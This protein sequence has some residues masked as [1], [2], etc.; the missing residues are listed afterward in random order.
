MR[1]KS[2]L[3]VFLILL[4]CCQKAHSEMGLPGFP[5][6]VPGA[7]LIVPFFEVGIDVSAH[8][9]DTLLVITNVSDSN[10][11]VH[12]HVWTIDGE[13]TKL[14]GNFELSANT[15]AS[16][17]VRAWIHSSTED[18]KN[19]LQ[20]TD[21][22]WR[23]FITFDL[24]S[25]ETNDPP[26]ATN[27]PFG[28][29]N[30]LTGYIYYTRLTQGSSNGMN[31]ISLEY[32]DT[33]LDFRINDFYDNNDGREEINADARKCS[34]NMIHGISCETDSTMDK[35]YA[36][37]F[38][39][40][41]LNVKTRFILFSWNPGFK[42]GPSVYCQANGCDTRYTFKIYDSN[43]TILSKYS[44][45]FDHTVN[46][47]ELTGQ[48]GAWIELD[49]LVEKGAFQTYAFSINSAT[50]DEETLGFKASWDAIFE[51]NMVP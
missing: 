29:K 45:K 40:P 32:L 21:S 41:S 23:G 11:T 3:L 4:A 14:Y 7:S 49:N 12:Y 28:S 46:V 15:S 34:R 35:I 33:T 9:E 10:C 51:A 18:V 22:Y 50:P 24:V 13:A 6:K 17:S 31:M 16:F 2:F 26:T 30:S 19:K 42:G 5:D 25:S 39:S 47:V 44:L 36:R 27:Y 48:H 38:L 20:V 1:I 8:P 43:G 37:V